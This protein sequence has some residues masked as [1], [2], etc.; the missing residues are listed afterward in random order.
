METKEKFVSDLREILYNSHIPN[1]STVI[2]L[3]SVALKDFELRYKDTSLVL[4]DDSDKQIFH[5][6]SGK[7]E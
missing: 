6:I 2:D 4:Y 1:I 5:K 3:V 7:D